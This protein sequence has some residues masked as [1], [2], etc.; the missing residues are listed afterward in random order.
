V[1]LPTTI[2][3]PVVDMSTKIEEAKKF[4]GDKW[5]LY[6]ENVTP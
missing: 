4:L 3:V 1:T 2:Q 5:L 6:K